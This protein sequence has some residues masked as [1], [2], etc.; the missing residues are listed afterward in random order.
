M[1]P[2]AMTMRKRT[3]EALGQ[4]STPAPA[5][6]EDEDDKDKSDEV[7]RRRK[8]SRRRR[9]RYAEALRTSLSSLSALSV[10]PQPRLFEWRHRHCLRYALPPPR[11]GGKHRV[12]DAV[13]AWPP[14]TPP[15]RDRCP[16][17][18]RG[19]LL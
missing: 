7:M 2:T 17:S 19:G 10:A 18:R 12:A 5:G 3:G 8:R 1:A 6:F 15:R 14:R 4:N 13:A 9:R 11:L 16:S